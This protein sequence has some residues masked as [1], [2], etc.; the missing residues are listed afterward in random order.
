MTSCV[1]HLDLVILH[2]KEQTLEIFNNE[3]LLTISKGLFTV[4]LAEMRLSG[5]RHYVKDFHFL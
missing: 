2:F 5:R 3:G 1:P 4:N